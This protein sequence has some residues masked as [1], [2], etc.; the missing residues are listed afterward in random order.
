MLNFLPPLPRPFRG[1]LNYLVKVRPLVSVTFLLLFF[2]LRNYWYFKTSK[3]W[4]IASVC[5]CIN[6]LFSSCFALIH[7]SPGHKFWKEKEV[8][9]LQF[10]KKVKANEECTSVRPWPSAP[11]PS[12]KTCHLP[13]C[14][15]YLL[16][17][18]LKQVQASSVV[19]YASSYSYEWNTCFLPSLFYVTLF[20]IFL[21]G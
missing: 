4:H 3:G 10:S 5:V 18:R 14:L 6:P 16:T 9:F 8:T 11:Y 17:Q 12:E 2:L 15:V 7:Q 19:M 20:E 21:P 1:N 13:F